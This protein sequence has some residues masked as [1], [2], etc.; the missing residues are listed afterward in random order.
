M[1]ISR[2]EFIVQAAATAALSALLK[3]G[4]Q[5]AVQWVIDGM[6]ITTVRWEATGRVHRLPLLIIHSDFEFHGR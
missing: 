6:Q 4:P 3:P 5:D 2:R 1:T